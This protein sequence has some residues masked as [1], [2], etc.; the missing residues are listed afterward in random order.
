MP[1]LTFSRALSMQAL[2]RTVDPVSFEI[3]YHKT[4]NELLVQILAQR[5]VSE[6][7]QVQNVIRR[8]RLTPIQNATSRR[9]EVDN[10]VSRTV[11]EPIRSEQENERN[12]GNATESG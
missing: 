6:C 1:R 4:L 3:L 11:M 5:G 10:V 9:L 7:S 8:T 2:L 12:H